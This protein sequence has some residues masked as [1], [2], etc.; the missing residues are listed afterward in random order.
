[1]IVFLSALALFALI[2]YLTALAFGAILWI[3]FL[4]YAWTF[5]PHKRSSYF[6]NGFWTAA[7]LGK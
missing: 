3:I 4:L 7:I 2:G 1:M 6:R 5:Y